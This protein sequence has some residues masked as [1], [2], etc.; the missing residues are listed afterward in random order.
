MLLFL[1][2]RAICFF[3]IK[4]NIYI[5]KTRSS[6]SFASTI[7]AF[8]QNWVLKTSLKR[9]TVCLFVFNFPI[10]L[11]LIVIL[12]N[13]YWAFSYT[14]QCEKSFSDYLIVILVLILYVVDNNDP[15]WRW[16]NGDLQ[17]LC[18]SLTGS[19]EVV[20]LK[21][22]PRHLLLVQHCPVLASLGSYGE[23]DIT[24]RN[25]CCTEKSATERDKPHPNNDKSGPTKNEPTDPC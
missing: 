1:W 23:S 21:S 13:I 24:L 11:W 8:C 9:N 15:T 20:K 4:V 2:Y 6:I 17:W 3:L 16:E 25:Q 12:A 19:W 10:A 22:K 14:R 5:P 7:L 18:G